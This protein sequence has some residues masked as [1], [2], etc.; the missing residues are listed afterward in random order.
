MSYFRLK[1]ALRTIGHYSFVNVSYRRAEVDQ[2]V[3]EFSEMLFAG[4]DVGRVDV[5]KSGVTIRIKMKKLVKG[6]LKS[7]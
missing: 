1:S 6:E 7:R 2:K 4:I 3:Y 5:Y